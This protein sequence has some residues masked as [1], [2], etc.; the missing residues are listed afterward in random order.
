M[1]ALHSFSEQ[2]G[3]TPLRSKLTCFAV[4]EKSEAEQRFQALMDEAEKGFDEAQGGEDTADEASAPPTMTV[5]EFRSL[6]GEDWQL[7]Q[8][9]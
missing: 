7:S 2:L 5:D 9:W 4:E 8:F 3:S 6:F 1:A